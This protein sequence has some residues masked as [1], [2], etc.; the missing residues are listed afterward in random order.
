MK[1]W[2]NTC[3]ERSVLPAAPSTIVGKGVQE[4]DS[5]VLADSPGVSKHPVRG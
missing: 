4:A 2:E 5:A 1:S 3:R